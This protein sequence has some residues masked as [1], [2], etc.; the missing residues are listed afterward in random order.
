MGGRGLRQQACGSSAHVCQTAGAELGSLYGGHAHFTH[1]PRYLFMRGW[2]RGLRSRRVK[3]KRL[4]RIS[5]CSHCITDTALK[6]VCM[7]GL[8]WV[9]IKPI[10][11]VGMVH[12]RYACARAFPPASPYLYP[13]PTTRMCHHNP[14]D[15]AGPMPLPAWHT[16]P[17]LLN[18][19]ALARWTYRNPPAGCSK[20]H[21]ALSSEPLHSCPGPVLPGL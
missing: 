6:K 9:R 15:P 18:V 1:P 7:R 17:R 14:S 16:C 4:L 19:Q 10:R 11:S 13:D 21:S 8:A 2:N 20:P 5:A 12:E 3:K